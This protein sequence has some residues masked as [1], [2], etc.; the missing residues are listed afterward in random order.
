M[1]F[2]FNGTNQRV[3]PASAPVTSPPFTLVCWFNASNTTNLGALLTLTPQ[4]GGLYETLFFR[5][6]LAGD[7]IQI[8]SNSNAIAVASTSGVTQNKWHHGC[9]V[10]A[11]TNSRTIYLD[12]GNSASSSNNFNPTT[13]NAFNI[14]SF[15]SA[16]NNFF[17]GKMAEVGIWNAAL[18]QPEIAS[19]ARGMTCDKVRPQSLVF[20]APLV[21]DLIDAKGGLTITNNNGATV[22]NHT[23]VYA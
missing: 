11:A 16:A 18:T 10:A 22:A 19:L 6:D 5:G 3:T 4:T 15:R 23:R 21:R 2:E 13:I 1:A 17:N 20:Y 7:P 12:G 9:F 14:G 8:L